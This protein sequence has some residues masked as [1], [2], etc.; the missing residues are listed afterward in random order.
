MWSPLFNHTLAHEIG[1]LVLHRELVGKG[2]YISIEKS[3][4]DTKSQLMYRGAAERS[5][6]GWVEWQANE[7]AISL[8][9]PKFYLQ[10]LVN[11]SQKKLRIY[12]NFGTIYLDDQNINSLNCR[13]IVKNISEISGASIPFIWSRLRHLGILQ[14]HRSNN[15]WKDEG[16]C[17]YEPILE[18]I[19]TL[20]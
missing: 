5:D 12:R 13:R 16:T 17:V 4:A 7:F 19:H 10:S 14:D 1:H 18:V 9:L 11:K 3:L 8:I 2:K 20:T 6:L 15:V